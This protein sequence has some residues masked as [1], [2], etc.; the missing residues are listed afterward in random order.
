MPELDETAALTKNN[1]EGIKIFR[2]IDLILFQKCICQRRHSEI[3]H[4]NQRFFRTNS[5]FY[6]L[7]YLITFYHTLYKLDADCVVFVLPFL[8]RFCSQ[9][10]KYRV[11][12]KLHSVNYFRVCA[13]DFILSDGNCTFFSCF[14]LFGLCMSIP[15]C[16]RRYR[17]DGCLSYDNDLLGLFLF[18]M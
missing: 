2:L 11:L 5:A 17:R 10:K 7:F 6:C 4:R 1:S 18:W 9:R 3:Y 14:F 15:F 12:Q 13:N 16:R 8:S